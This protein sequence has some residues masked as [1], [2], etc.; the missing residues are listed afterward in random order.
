MAKIFLSYRRDDSAA[1]CGRIYDHLR[2]HFGKENIYK[3]IDNIPLGA[4][5]REH[6][7][8]AIAEC[9]VEL[10][11]I[12]QRWLTVT[13][14]AGQRRLDVANDPV[15]VEVEEGLRRGIPVIPL[16]VDRAPMP[17]ED[18][19]PASIRPLANRNGLDI[20]NGRHFDDDVSHLIAALQQSLGASPATPSKTRQAN[21]PASAARTSKSPP[22]IYISH[23]NADNVFTRRLSDDLRAAGAE[24]WADFGSLSG[25]GFVQVM[26]EELSR[27]DWLIVVVSRDAVASHWVQM[28]V[29]AALSLVHGGQMKGIIPVTAAPAAMPPLW[30]VYKG[31]DATRDYKTAI[32]D[33]LKAVG[34]K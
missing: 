25:G 23:S 5:F 32:M 6:V 19:L 12:G 11:I 27:S 7:K 20:D 14:A 18:D 4:D 16:L 1:A 2:Q 31:V 17:S 9:A 3:D 8:S 15:R 21:P 34:L 24:I 29:E 33:I 26:N 10:V 22:R 30:N 13:N 28:E